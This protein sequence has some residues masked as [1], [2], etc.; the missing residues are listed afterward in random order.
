MKA[1]GIWTLQL[2]QHEIWDINIT[3][4]MYT[5]ICDIEKMLLVSITYLVNNGICDK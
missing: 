5:L 1:G 2:I 3:Y 4:Y